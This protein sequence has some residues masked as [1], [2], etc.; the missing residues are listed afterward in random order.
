MTRHHDNSGVCQVACGA[1]WSLAVNTANRVFIAEA[2]GI[3]PVV[4]ALTRHGDNS[5][6]CDASCGALRNLA[7]NDANKVSI[8][9]GGGI[10]YPWWRR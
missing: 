3:G 2:G 10:V 6:V 9:E 8:A 4:A 1:L 5:G 7:V